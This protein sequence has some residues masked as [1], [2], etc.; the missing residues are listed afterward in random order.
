V[1]SHCHNGKQY[2]GT[3]FAVFLTCLLLMRFESYLAR[4]IKQKHEIITG[5]KK[6]ML[7]ARDD[8]FGTLCKQMAYL[9]CCYRFRIESN[10]Q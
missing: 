8:S 7:N 6:F 9:L 4:V 2:F 10:V 1:K 5:D 3:W